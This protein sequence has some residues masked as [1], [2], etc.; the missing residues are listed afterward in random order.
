M[1]PVNLVVGHRHE[2]DLYPL[3]HWLARERSWVW[4]RR[5]VNRHAMD[6]V[7]SPSSWEQWDLSKSLSVSRKVATYGDR[8][9]E[10]Y[11]GRTWIGMGS[12]HVM[13]VGVFPAGCTSIRI[14]VTLGYE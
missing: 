3:L 12:V 9:Q 8:P 2:L 4:T 6:C 14:V 5:S 11:A 10:V 13:L 1:G 7:E